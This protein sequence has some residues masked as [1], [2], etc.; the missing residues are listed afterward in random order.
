MP[1]PCFLQS[2]SRHTGVDGAT[3]AREKA[4]RRANA[5]GVVTLEQDGEGFEFVITYHVVRP[6]VGNRDR[7]EAKLRL[8]I[9]DAMSVRVAML[10]SY[11]RQPSRDFTGWMGKSRMA[12]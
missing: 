12:W 3:D 11:P 5:A 8:V 7:L 9:Y 4:A 2:H 1:R 10:F 6:T